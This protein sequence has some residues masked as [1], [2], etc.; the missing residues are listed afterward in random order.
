MK[1]DGSE[2]KNL[3]KNPAYDIHHDWSPDGKRIVFE[4][5]RDALAEVYVMNADGSE[6]KRLTHAPDVDEAYL[7]WSPDGKKIA[8]VSIKLGNCEIYVMDANGSNQKGLTN[9]R[10]T[11]LLRWSPDG[12]KLAFELSRQSIIRIPFLLEG[13]YRAEV[14]V[15]NADGSEKK[16][17]TNAGGNPVWSP[18]PLP[19]KEE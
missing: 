8:F 7:D 5:D 1:A 6:Q 19:S 15:M 11:R 16:Q 17:L 14:Y 10:D 4:S 3:T 13:S 12:K 9:E 2:Q 18:V